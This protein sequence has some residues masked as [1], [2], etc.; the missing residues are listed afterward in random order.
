MNNWIEKIVDDIIV[1]VEDNLHD[2]INLPD[3][4]IEND[5]IGYYEYW[6]QKCYDEGQ[7]YPIITGNDKVEIELDIVC[8]KRLLDKIE[9]DINNY[10]AY[11]NVTLMDFELDYTIDEIFVHN[12]YIYVV[13]LWSE[14]SYTY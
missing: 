4:E 9:E 13:I 12:G 2:V 5:G 7:D 14:I 3:V 6:G 10:F 11:N 1:E 8:S